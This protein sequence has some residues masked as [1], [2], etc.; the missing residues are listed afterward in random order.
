[1]RFCIGM[2]QLPGWGGTV[3]SPEGSRHLMQSGPMETCFVWTSTHT[4]EGIEMIG[5]LVWH[6]PH[7]VNLLIPESTTYPQPAFVVY[8]A[9]PG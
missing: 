3:Q 2:G 9:C 7:P 6:I 5:I 1:M 4:A 8:T